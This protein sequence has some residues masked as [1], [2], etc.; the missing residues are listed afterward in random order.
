MS[1]AVLIVADDGIGL[2]DDVT[3]IKLLFQNFFINLF[4]NKALTCDL[5]NF[6]KTFQL[7]LGKKEKLITYKAMES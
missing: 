3:I 1:A 2:D 4:L 5:R 6:E 7:K